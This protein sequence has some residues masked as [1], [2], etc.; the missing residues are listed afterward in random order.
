VKA[1]VASKSSGSN[2][3]YRIASLI[4]TQDVKLN[5]DRLSNTDLLNTRLNSVQFDLP[6]SPAANISSII[7]GA[8]AFEGITVGAIR[9][10]GDLNPGT[11]YNRDPIASPF[12]PFITGYQARD[13]IFTISNNQSSFAVGEYITQVNPK[14]FVK[15]TVGDVSPF[16]DGEKVHAANSTTNFIANGVVFYR[17]GGGSYIDLELTEGT[18]PTTNNF[19][20]KSLITT[21]NT[22]ISNAVPFIGSTTARGQVKDNIG[23][24]LYVK[25]LQLGNLFQPNKLVRG[26]LTGTTANV[27]NIVVESFRY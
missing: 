10:L 21:A 7:Y 23:D 18:F 3:Q 6:Y 8:L 14:S 12:Q 13:Y 26:S 15:V 24:K 20:I 17:D 22:Y 2:A 5:T 1:F 9:T 11:G 25:R 19:S 4:D 16:R 27:V